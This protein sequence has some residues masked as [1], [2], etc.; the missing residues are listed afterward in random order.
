MEID[1]N[2]LK[3]S[4]FYINP[5]IPAGFFIC[6]LCCPVGMLSQILYYKTQD[7][8]SSRNFQN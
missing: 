4:C 5:A 6:Y 1:Q 3:W 8:V 7:V 2:Q